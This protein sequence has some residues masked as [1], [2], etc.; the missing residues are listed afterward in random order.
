MFII[1]L[2]TV[3]W[4]VEASDIPSIGCIDIQRK[5]PRG[6]STEERDRGRNSKRWNNPDAAINPVKDNK[7]CRSGYRFQGNGVKKESRW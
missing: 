4:V 5:K 1:S 6:E 3:S 2:Q 7:S